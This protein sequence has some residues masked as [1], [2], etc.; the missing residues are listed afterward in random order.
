MQKVVLTLLKPF[1]LMY[2][3]LF[4]LFWSTDVNSV[5][6]AEVNLNA[7]KKNAI[8]KPFKVA[9]LKKIGQHF[10]KS[11]INDVVLSL[12]SVSM[13]EY[14]KG[15]G[16]NSKSI[17][18][19]IPYSLR[20]LPQTAEDHRLCNDFSCLCF[21]LATCDTFEESIALV[22]K[23]T[24]ALKKSVYPHG[25]TTLTAAIAALP[26]IIGQ[27]IMMWV[28]SKATMIM[29]NVAGPKEG[30]VYGG[31]LC[32]GFIALVPG[33]G[34]LACGISALSMGPNLNMAI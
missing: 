13:R 25:V 28:V 3:F 19:L 34:D 9:A 7:H 26:G 8:L 27:L 6:P 20:E 10:N 4:F 16:D 15:R 17:N 30:M 29:S 24:R 33:L 2:A 14:M 18:M 31:A 21:T 11:T 32:S 5:K 12:I 23:Q 1:T 22:K